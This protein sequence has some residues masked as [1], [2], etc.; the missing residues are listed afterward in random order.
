MSVY[1][2]YRSNAVGGIMKIFVQG[3][4]MIYFV[5]AV[6]CISAVYVMPYKCLNADNLATLAILG[7]LCV[8]MF[9]VQYQ[10]AGDKSKEIIK[11]LFKGGR[12]W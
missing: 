7:W 11:K 3:W 12:Y 2:I 5:M 1:C 8:I 9:C 4:R 10:T 6:V